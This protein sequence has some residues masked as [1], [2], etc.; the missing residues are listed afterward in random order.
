MRLVFLIVSFSVLVSCASYRGVGDGSA[1]SSLFDVDGHRLNLIVQGAG[2]TVI[3]SGGGGVNDPF[4]GYSALVKELSP[5]A[6]VAL[7][8]RA[9][10]GLSESTEIP[11]EIDTVVRE[12]D[13]L[14]SK[15]N[16]TPPFVLVGHSMAS[17][18]VLRYAQTYPDKVKAVVLLEGAP[19]KYYLTMKM[20]SDF[21]QSLYTTFFG[22]A[23]GNALE[24]KSLVQNA[25]EVIDSGTLR[26]I[27]LYYFYAGSN[28]ITGWID[29]QKEFSQ[30]SDRAE[31]ILVKEAD[32]F[33]YQKHSP[34]IAESIL[35]LLR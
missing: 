13:S 16:L 32:H 34:L 35:R 3:L 9:G 20:P 10:Y 15:A 28:G 14:F 24:V 29:A 23:K 6:R 12:L 18:E 8:E 7:Y 2:P 33:I 27:P 21:E 17:L 31:G 1:K 5:V 11:R 25:R 26:G 4:F 19:P 22:L 30:Y